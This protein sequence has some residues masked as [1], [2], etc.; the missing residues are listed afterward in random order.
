[1]LSLSI[2]G[3]W[4]NNKKLLQ[5]I[6]LKSNLAGIIFCL[7]EEQSAYA[8]RKK[9]TNNEINDRVMG[10]TFEHQSILYTHKL[11]VGQRR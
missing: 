2:V 5:K 4:L 6:L 10:A 7:L 8:L 1:M 11:N 3:E 9:G